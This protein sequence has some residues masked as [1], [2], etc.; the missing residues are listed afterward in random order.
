MCGS[1]V[2][3]KRRR[4]LEMYPE[5][6]TNQEPVVF[7]SSIIPWWAWLRSSHPPEAEL[8]NGRAAMVGFFMA[9]IVD[10]LTG[11]DVVGHTGNLVCKAG[12]VG[13][14]LFRQTEDFKKLKN[15]ADEAT[16]YNKQWQDQNSDS[17]N[18]I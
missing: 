4:L 16:M 2:E 5:S 11:L 8:L 14:I 1:L 6:A 13:V 12:V 18:K 10:S 3:A 7:R 15:L 9:Y 17:G